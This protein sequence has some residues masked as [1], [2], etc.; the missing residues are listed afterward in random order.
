M[1]NPTKCLRSHVAVSSSDASL[2]AKA[3]RTRLPE[4]RP[5]GSCGPEVLQSFAINLCFVAKYEFRSLPRSHAAEDNAVKQRVS[6][7]SVV[8]MHATR[9]L[10]CCVK[11]RNWAALAHDLSFGVHF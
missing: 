9:H 3:L 6:T 1:E 10:P 4:L 11:A 5:A 2:Q 7:E 8:A